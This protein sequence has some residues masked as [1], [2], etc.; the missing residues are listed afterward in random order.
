M[1]VPEI[2]RNI[3]HNSSLGPERTK[4]DG[5]D[6]KPGACREYYDLIEILESWTSGTAT[7]SLVVKHVLKSLARIVR[8]L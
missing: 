1:D 6:P 7:I 4:V 3:P 8:H 5:Y 2:A